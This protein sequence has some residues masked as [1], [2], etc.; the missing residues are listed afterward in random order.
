MIKYFKGKDTN[1]S[2]I[3]KIPRLNNIILGRERQAVFAK[4]YL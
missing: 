3:D 4:P 2:D 1:N